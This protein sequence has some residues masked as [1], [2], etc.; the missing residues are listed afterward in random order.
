MEDNARFHLVQ[1]ISRNNSSTCDLSGLDLSLSVLD[2]CRQD[3]H[4]GQSFLPPERSSPFSAI[5]Y[6]S[7][8]DNVSGVCE[9]PPKAEFG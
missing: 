8:A 6:Y 5:E 7:M 1:E 3:N 9:V 2:R 4:L